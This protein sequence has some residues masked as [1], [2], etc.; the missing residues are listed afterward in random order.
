MDIPTSAPAEA[1]APAPE[2]APVAATPATPPP[3]PAAPV[4]APKASAKEI[5]ASLS[6][7]Q[8]K[9]ALAGK[10]D[11]IQ[12]PKPATPPSAQE[13]QPAAPVE[14]PAVSAE[15]ATPAEPVAEP[16]TEAA[17]ADPAEVDIGGESYRVRLRGQDKVAAQ[18]AKEHGITVTEAVLKLH[19]EAQAKLTPF[20]TVGTETA[21]AA[22]PA[23]AVDPE[24]Q[25]I[26]TSITER[27]TKLAQLKQDRDKALDDLDNKR[28]NQLNDEIYAEM[29]SIDRLEGQKQTHEVR[30]KEAAAARV[31]ASRNKVFEEY[32]VFKKENSMERLALEGYISVVYRDRPEVFQ[33]SNW[34]HRLATEFAQANNIRKAGAPAPAPTPAAPPTLTPTQ[35]AKPTLAKPQPTQVP[36]GARLLS[37]AD[38][39]RPSA[40]S[41]MTR[42]EALALVRKDPRGY[43]QNIQKIN[44]KRT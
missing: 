38:G 7:E 29:L 8:R 43:F 36:S 34:P 12:A 26:D 15:P 25:R 14:A 1:P 2:A 11:K 40:P 41:P 5:I 22:P 4:E 30:Q 13:I 27:T 20:A 23:P 6:P 42:D 37:G 28:V 33:D 19:T 16:T 44:G 31:D 18:Y 3:T 39:V 32:P 17:P 35:P 21:P 10:F 9:L 24:V